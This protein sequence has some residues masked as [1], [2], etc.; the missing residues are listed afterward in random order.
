M[1]SETSNL[2]NETESQSAIARWAI[3][4]HPMV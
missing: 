2:L 1:T 4:L 3:I